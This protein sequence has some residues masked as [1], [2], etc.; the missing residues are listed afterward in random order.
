M[1]RKPSVIAVEGS[2]GVEGSLKISRRPFSSK[3][4]SVNVPPVS[5][6]MR[7]WGAGDGATRG[8]GDAGT[9]G[10]GEGGRGG[11]GEGG[12]RGRGEA[13]MGGR[14]DGARWGRGDEEMG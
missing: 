4:K 6:P 3:T 7:R 10:G 13:G 11:G 9:G 2:A 8:L 5:T 14:G 12:T 1:R